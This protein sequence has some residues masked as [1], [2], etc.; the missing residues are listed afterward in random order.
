MRAVLLFV[1]FTGV[2][3]IVANELVK[4]PGTMVEYKYVEK[5]SL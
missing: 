5:E 2:V 4:R 3:L 1:F